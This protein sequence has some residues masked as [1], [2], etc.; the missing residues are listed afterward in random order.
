MNCRRYFSVVFMPLLAALACSGLPSLKPPSVQTLE[1]REGA[2]ATVGAV[3]D[4]KIKGAPII[5]SPTTTQS[6][7]A[8]NPKF[9]EAYAKEQYDTAE[10]SQAGKTYT[11]NVTL[12]QRGETALWGTSW[13]TTT[14]DLLR[15]N[16]EHI[17][18]E[19]SVNGTVVDN[20]QLLLFEGKSDNLV[21]RYYFAAVYGWPQG[22]TDLQI[23]VT[24]DK[25]IN[26]GLS[27]YPAGTHYYIY[28]VTA[29]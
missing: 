6:K 10:L 1:A 26:D 8:D 21:C 27:D 22:R 9:L 16:W 28:H 2:T 20:S 7:L 11:Y 5:G 14:E 19:F 23:K 3:A 12:N 15:G 25:Q 4:L 24:F 18:L 17:R 13:C 29:P